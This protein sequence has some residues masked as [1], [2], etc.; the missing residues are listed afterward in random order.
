MTV[1]GKRTIAEL[2]DL[3]AAKDYTIAQVQKDYEGIRADWD[4][5]DHDAASKWLAQWTLFR[6]RYA[7]ARAVAQ[8]AIDGASGMFS[9]R[10]TLN[11]AEDEYVGVLNALTAPGSEGSFKDTDAQ[12]LYNRLVAAK[13]SPVPLGNMPQPKPSSDADLAVHGAADTLIKQGEKAVADAKK[14]DTA[15]WIAGGAAVAAA[16]YIVSR[17]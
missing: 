11:P 4:K 12:G 17:R 3:L 15:K 2:K 6:A 13:G 14:S 7:K 10:D 5:R 8:K 9:V 16:L 1:L